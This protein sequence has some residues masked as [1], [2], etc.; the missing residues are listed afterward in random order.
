MVDA[1]LAKGLDAHVRDFLDLGF[2]PATFDSV[3][4]MN[5]LLHVP[6]AD[7]ARV[8]AAISGVLRPSGLFFMGV[9]GGDHREGAADED[10][11]VPPRF[12]SLRTD[13]EIQELVRPMFEVIDFHTIPLKRAGF[14]F[15]SLTLRRLQ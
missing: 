14:H 3:Y 1:C 2:P 9:Y 7:I 6:N 15:Q 12:F 10:D 4:A 11:H 5:C 8:L 13:Q